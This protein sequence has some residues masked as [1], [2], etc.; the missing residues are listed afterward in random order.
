MRNFMS[1]YKFTDL[2]HHPILFGKFKKIKK[3][4]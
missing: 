2:E 3:F 1:K 4:S